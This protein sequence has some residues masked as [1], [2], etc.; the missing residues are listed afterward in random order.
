MI[1]HNN[2]YTAISQNIYQSSN[3]ELITSLMYFL[4][5]D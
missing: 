1:L 5:R 2:V 3:A 4:K